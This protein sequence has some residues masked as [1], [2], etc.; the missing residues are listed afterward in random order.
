MLE[1]QTSQAS[2]FIVSINI[3]SNRHMVSQNLFYFLKIYLFIIE[4]VQAMGVAGKGRGR[5][6]P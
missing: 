2:L 3:L 1:F 6:R 4:R 5:S